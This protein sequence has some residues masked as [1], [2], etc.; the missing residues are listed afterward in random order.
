MSHAV[1]NMSLSCEWPIFL[2]TEKNECWANVLKGPPPFGGTMKA[3]PS[4]PDSQ[5]VRARLC[6]GIKQS[7]A[8]TSCGC[9]AHTVVSI[10]RPRL[11]PYER[12]VQTS[13]QLTTDA[14]KDQRSGSCQ[15]PR[16]Q[17][18]VDVLATTP[19]SGVAGTCAPTTGRG[20]ACGSAHMSSLHV[21]PPRRRSTHFQIH[22][23]C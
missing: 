21:M 11:E 6:R 13:L 16:C 22:D 2:S 15:P 3:H 20:R 5:M 8:R 12:I 17:R 23:V 1:S 10:R 18:R 9:I 14:Y 4:Q 19:A 7:S